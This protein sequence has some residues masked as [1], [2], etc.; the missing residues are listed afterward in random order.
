M[1][2]ASLNVAQPGI[3][4]RASRLHLP[5]LPLRE[6]FRPRYNRYNDGSEDDEHDQ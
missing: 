1:I 4:Y 2:G 6:S 3:E 5:F